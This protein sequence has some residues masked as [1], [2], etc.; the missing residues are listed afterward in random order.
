MKLFLY[1]IISLLGLMNC[2]S[3]DSKFPQVKKLSEYKETVFVSTLENSFS[4]KEN[5]IYCVTLLYAWD[6]VR[7]VINE[8]PNIDKNLKDLTLLND[9]KSFQDVLN[10]D[11]YKIESEVNGDLIRAKAEFKKSLPFEEKLTPM[12]NKLK[13]M[14]K[15]VVAFGAHGRNKQITKNIQIVYYKDDHD[16]IIKISPKDREHE[17]ILYK[18]PDN[19]QNMAE[20]VKVVEEKTKLGEE[21]APLNWKYEWGDKDILIIP[22]I[23]FNIEHNYTSL[24]KQQFSTNKNRVFTV[25]KAWQRTAFVLN[26]NG[27]EIESESEVTVTDGA[28]SEKAKPKN[29]IFDKT[30][31]IM[32]KKKNSKNPYFG[33]WI[34]NTELLS[35]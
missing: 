16:F 18:T 30:F 11:E 13:F 28:P 14:G 4:Q 25:E 32:L 2:T 17:I 10:P 20:I 3:Q 9:S 8:P 35:R 21:E 27:A 19:Y 15:N 29:L 23:Q 7:K 34:T 12:P 31:F 33:A 6:E 26:E 1:F 24:E 22:T 5:A